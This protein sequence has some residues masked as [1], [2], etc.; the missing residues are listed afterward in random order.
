MVIDNQ[1]NPGKYNR[2]QLRQNASEAAAIY[3]SADA[4]ANV[5]AA[6]AVT[7]LNADADIAAR[8]AYA[9]A[10]ALLDADADTAYAVYA[11]AAIYADTA[12]TAYT[13]ATGHLIDRYFRLSGEDRQD[14]IDEINKDNK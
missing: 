1:L 7:L 10:V 8:F 12:Y 3:S 14:Y 11:T 4:A 13:A 6:K 9:K 2:E 5:A